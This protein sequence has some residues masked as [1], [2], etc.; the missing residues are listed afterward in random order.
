MGWWVIGGSISLIISAPANNPSQ[1]EIISK[2]IGW[3]RTHIW[4]AARSPPAVRTDQ[5]QIQRLV[6]LDSI[7]TDDI[8]MM[9]KETNWCCNVP[10]DLT[11]VTSDWTEKL[12]SVK[13]WLPGRGWRCRAES[14]QQYR[15]VHQQ[16]PQYFMF[17][18]SGLITALKERPQC[19]MAIQPQSARRR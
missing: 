13:A 5:D 8:L 15:D 14:D 3:L 17:D 1:S 18:N 19:T 4:G 6:G 9:R 7:F 16:C 10:F 12:F 11:S 2:W